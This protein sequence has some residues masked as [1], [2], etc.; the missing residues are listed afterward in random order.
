MSARVTLGGV[1]IGGAS[2]CDFELG[3]GTAPVEKFWTVSE[4]RARSIEQGKPLTYEKVGAGPGGKTTTFTGLYCLGVHPATNPKQ[5]VLHVVDRR[6]IWSRKWV[7]AA[8]NVVRTTGDKFLLN[9]TVIEN[10]IVQP[11]MKY[12]KW[13]LYPPDN[14]GTPWTAAQV[15]DYVFGQLECPYRVDGQLPE[16]EIKDLPLADPGDKALERVLA[17]LP[18][19]DVYIDVDGTAVVFNT[20]PPPSNGIATV[21]RDE[22]PFPYLV[23]RHTTYPGDVQIVARKVLRPARVHVLFTPECEVRF[24]FTE[25]GTVLRDENYLTNVAPAPEVT[26]TLTDGR[27]VGRGTWVPVDS[28]FSAWGAFGFRGRAM[29]TDILRKNAL[30]HGWASFEQEFGN[31]P[32]EAPN[33]IYQQ[34][35]A[36][37]VRHWRRTFKIADH[38][39]Q[40]CQSITAKRVAIL[41]TET[42]AYAPAEAY[43][44][45]TRRP[46][47]RGYASKEGAANR[48]QGWAAQGYADQLADAKAAPA[49]VAVVDQSA[50]VFTVDPQVDPF[51]L[52]Q[53]MVLG[54]P[55]GVG[56][57]PAGT[58]PS[59]DLGEANRQRDELYAQWDRVELSSTFK[60]AT[61]LTVVPASPN[62]LRKLHEVVIS[63]SDCSTDGDGPDV[64]VRVLPG[65]MTARFG[66]TDGGGQSIVD[67]IRGLAVL[68]VD[69]LVNAELVKDVA[70]ATAKRTYMLYRDTPAGSAAVDMDPSIKP[71]GNMSSVR[72][73][74]TDGVTET[75]V[76]FGPVRRPVD[77]WGFLDTSTRRVILKTLKDSPT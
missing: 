5:R 63:A 4:A 8:F 73:M 40:R 47:M 17:F 49:L 12:A 3:V 6:W 50:G 62:D 76:T 10:A 61:I 1:V 55:G 67:A 11:E 66:W 19:A 9:T 43:C 59:Q 74:L 15:L 75:V 21:L 37:A 30:K 38:F 31:S 23:R 64:Y 36:T 72:H 34:R 68:P 45:W 32:N 42:G 18:G 54:Y 65:V 51:G 33:V 25:N 71:S 46:S 58:V 27:R 7:E 20:L 44:D 16:V 57:V 53:A 13:S 35:A 22:P 26:T 52:S 70:L 29:S 60:L 2:G 39:V 77:I 56:S 69:A 24:N 48:G 41:N 14:G 28:L